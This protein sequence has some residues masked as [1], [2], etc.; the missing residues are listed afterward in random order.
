[1]RLLRITDLMGVYDASKKHHKG[2]KLSEHEW[3]LVGELLA[4]DLEQ[5]K[6]G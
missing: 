4:L 5:Q 2:E 6:K 3:D 1:M